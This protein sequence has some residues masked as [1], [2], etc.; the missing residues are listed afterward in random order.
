MLFAAALSF[1]E[2]EAQERIPEYNPNSVFPIAESEIMYK[3]RIWRRMD[4]NEKMNEPF[5]AF[6]NE[7][8]KIIID[9]V[10]DGRLFPYTNDS[11]MRRMPKEEFLENLKVPQFGAPALTDEERAMGFTDDDGWGWGDDN[12]GDKP[13]TSRDFYFYPRQ[14]SVLEIMEDF[15]F[16]KRRSRAYWDI[17]TV[18]LIIPAKEFPETGFQ[19]EVATFRYKDLYELFKSMPQ[20]ALWFNYRNQRENRN[21]ADAFTMRLFSANIIK[22]W[23][24]QNRYL[25][26][27]FNKHPREALLA[28]KWIEQELM[29]FEHNLWSY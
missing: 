12:G 18:K 20:E 16:D 25:V 26:D 21:L 29:E 6:G 8:T 3:R 17:Q 11:L 24:P 23:D 14:V 10:N 13:S 5:F 15:I 19:R 4:L 22:Y 7:I 28:A 9:A 1:H 2:V 27:I